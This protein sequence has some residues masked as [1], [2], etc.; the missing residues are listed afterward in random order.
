MINEQNSRARKMKKCKKQDVSYILDLKNHLVYNKLAQKTK[1]T[2]DW[3][4]QLYTAVNYED[5]NGAKILR[6][7]RP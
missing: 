4:Q 7:P 6:N 5:M 3:K 2:D 1:I